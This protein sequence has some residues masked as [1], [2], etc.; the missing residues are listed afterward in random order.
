[1]RLPYSLTSSGLGFIE[2]QS[3]WREPSPG[4]A[5]TR[6]YGYTSLPP[7]TITMRCSI[8]RLG[9]GESWVE[10]STIRVHLIGAAARAI[11]HP[12]GNRTVDVVDLSEIAHTV[13]RDLHHP[14]HGLGPANGWRNGYRPLHVKP[15]GSPKGVIGA[16]KS[17]VWHGAGYGAA[18]LSPGDKQEQAR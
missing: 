15:V 4:K 2:G 18:A 10:A 11:R 17:R 3:A 12:P 7:S 5:G 6:G 8:K 14:D 9:A 16:R 1:M 13:I